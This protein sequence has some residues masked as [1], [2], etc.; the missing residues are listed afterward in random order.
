MKGF[1]LLNTTRATK[2]E[3]YR[4]QILAKNKYMWGL[5]VLGLITAVIAYYMEFSG[6]MKVDDYM[7]GVYCGIGVGLFVCGIMMLI[8]NRNLLKDE[9]KLKEARL[10]MTDERNVEISS[11]ALKAAATVLV[12]V[13]YGV[14]LIGGLFY[15]ILGKLMAMLICLFVV[16][17]AIAWKVLDHKM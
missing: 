4:K 3:E 6:K 14:L 17:Y 2:N 15:P 5:I 10:K 12:V 7:L 1:C 11:K 13:L 8:R 9:A 16:T